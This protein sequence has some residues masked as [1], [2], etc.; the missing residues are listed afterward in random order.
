MSYECP[1]VSVAIGVSVGTKVLSVVPGSGTVK[2]PGKLY[3]AGITVPP[4]DVVLNVHTTV[5]V[6]VVERKRQI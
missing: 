2:W 1:L 6:H 4:V 5:Y 3:P